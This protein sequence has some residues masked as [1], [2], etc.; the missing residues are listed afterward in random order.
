[1]AENH[2]EPVILDEVQ[3]TPELLNGV[4][5]LIEPRKLRFV[6]TCSTARSLRRSGLNLLAGRARRTFQESSELRAGLVSHRC[7]ASSSS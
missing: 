6:L 7:V 5:R 4:H 2:G 1:M 3:R